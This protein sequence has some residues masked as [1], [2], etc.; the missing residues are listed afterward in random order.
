[1]NTLNNIQ[2]IDIEMRE[3]SP[4]RQRIHKQLFDSLQLQNPVFMGEDDNKGIFKNDQHILVPEHEKPLTSKQK[5][6]IIEEQVSD[7]REMPPQEIMEKDYLKIK[8]NLK[9][10]FTQYKIVA[11]LDKYW[12]S[13]NTPVSEHRIR[14]FRQDLFSPEYTLVVTNEKISNTGFQMGLQQQNYNVEVSMQT[15]QSGTVYKK[16]E[17]NDPCLAVTANSQF[18][19]IYLKSGSIKIYETR[20]GILLAPYFQNANLLFLSSENSGNLAFIDI[21]GAISVL[22]VHK[23]SVI[24]EDKTSVKKL[25]INL[26]EKLMKDT[27][28][29]FLD[30]K[31]REVS[32]EHFISLFYLHNNQIFIEVTLKKNHSE[33]QLLSYNPKLESWEEMSKIPNTI[34]SDEKLGNIGNVENEDDDLMMIDPEAEQKTNFGPGNVPDE[35]G[36]YH[37]D[38]SMDEIVT[39]IGLTV[40]ILAYRDHFITPLKGDTFESLEAQ[41][42]LHERLGHKEEFF[43]C[44]ESYIMK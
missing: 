29:F 38:K 41:M 31:Q 42:L 33:K 36:F 2:N 17:K 12:K 39:S 4:E 37:L 19:A 32:L 27:Q 28:G 21:H 35:R 44:L 9:Y 5:N 3:A 23:K 34:L 22:D 15:P 20:T 16:E 1:M 8:A 25:L 18:F 14:I 10:E 43:Q 40:N 26:C 24:F 30:D 6:T 7:I 13:F 11:D